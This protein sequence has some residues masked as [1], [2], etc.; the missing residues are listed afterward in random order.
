MSYSVPDICF[1]YQARAFSVTFLQ[2]TEFN[3]LGLVIILYCGTFIVRSR[4]IA[5]S[6]VTAYGLDNGGANFGSR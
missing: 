2:R 1:Q 5:A 3:V 4:D 6:I